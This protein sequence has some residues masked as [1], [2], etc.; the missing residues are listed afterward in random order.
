MLEILCLQV[1]R[2]RQYKI[3]SFFTMKWTI[4]VND[5]H[6]CHVSELDKTNCA[7]KDKSTDVQYIIAA[8]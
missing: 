2:S 6:W 5:N 4:F 3:L 8:L 1:C 7:K